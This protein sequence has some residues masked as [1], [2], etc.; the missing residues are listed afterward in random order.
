MS[1]KKKPLLDGRYM[2]NAGLPQSVSKAAS[3]P[4]RLQRLKSFTGKINLSLKAHVRV[5]MEVEVG[6]LSH[7]VEKV[8]PTCKRAHPNL[9]G[10]TTRAN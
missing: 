9:I 1:Q 5:R 10:V 2:D 6:N 4:R 8:I 7:L 3:L